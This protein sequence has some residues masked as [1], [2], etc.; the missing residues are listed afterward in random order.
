M[1]GLHVDS[2]GGDWRKET[3]I[4]PGRG[5]GLGVKA[6][7]FGDEDN[8]AVQAESWFERPDRSLPRACTTFHPILKPGIPSRFRVASAVAIVDTGLK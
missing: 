2:D 3:V 4:F 5:D 7:R 8:G 6:F 1:Q